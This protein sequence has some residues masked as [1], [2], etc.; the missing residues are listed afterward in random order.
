MLY[1]KRQIKIEWFSKEL[2]WIKENF[3]LL[4]LIL[5]YFLKFRKKIVIL[6]INIE[7]ILLKFIELISLKNSIFFAKKFN[8]NLEDLIIN[9]NIKLIWFFWKERKILTNIKILI[10][11]NKKNSKI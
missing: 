8:Y 2:Y 4:K 5:K 1:K 6:E 11:L 3:N 7:L 10:D 9:M